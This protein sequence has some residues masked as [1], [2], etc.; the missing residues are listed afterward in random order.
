MKQTEQHITIQEAE[1]LCQLY[2]DCKLSLLEEAELEYVL[3]LSNLNSP[4]IR[5]TR[6]LMGITPNI[7]L[8]NSS[9]SFILRKMEKRGFLIWTLRATACVIIL[10]GSILL[11]RNSI[12]NT[13]NEKICIAYV[14]GRKVSGERAKDIAEADVVKME[15]FMRIATTQQA[16][17]NAKVEKFM[18][19]KTHT[20]K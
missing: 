13:A 4:L 3:M 10:L 20:R 11:I 5:E 14:E 15:Q 12:N 18:N 8:N 16:L 19:H 2:M 9:Q 1:Q 7:T 17:E 6:V